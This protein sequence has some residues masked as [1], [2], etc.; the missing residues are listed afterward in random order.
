VLRGIQ[1][2]KSLDLVE[3]EAAQATVRE[4]ES[5]GIEA[6]PISFADAK[7]KYLTDVKR[8]NLAPPT[9]KKYKLVMRQFPL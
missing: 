8:R 9:E 1:I 5:V 2:R 7:E 4:W 6:A 3:W